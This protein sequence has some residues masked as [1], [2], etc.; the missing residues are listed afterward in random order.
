MKKK[1]STRNKVAV[2]ITVDMRS[3][4]VDD[5]GKPFGLLRDE[6][7]GKWVL[8]ACTD[9]TDVEMFEAALKV[10]A[11]LLPTGEVFVGGQKVRQC[12]AV[13]ARRHQEKMANESA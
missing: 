10:G 3:C 2:P 13:E 12:D 6:K 8:F 11:L 7:R 1:A 5:I 4:D 9:T